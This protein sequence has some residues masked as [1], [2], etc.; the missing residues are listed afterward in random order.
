MNLLPFFILILLMVTPV[1]SHA[2]TK[3]VAIYGD[4][5]HVAPKERETDIRVVLVSDTHNVEIPL[6]LFPS[7]DLLLHAGDHTV[8]GTKA[9]MQAAASWLKALATRYTHGCVTVGGNHDGSLDTQS[10]TNVLRVSTND[11]ERARVLAGFSEDEITN[12]AP[13]QL[14]SGARIRLLNHE[15]V[16]VAGLR[17]FGSP[18]VP[19]SPGSYR[20]ASGDPR[21]YLGF[22]REG[23]ALQK[24][25]A[26]IPRDCHILM[27]HAP[28]RGLLDKSLQYGGQPRAQPIEIGAPEL[29]AW[30]ET[31]Y[32][33]CPALHVFGHEHDSR[34]VLKSSNFST[35]FCNAA[36]VNGDRSVLHDG[37]HYHMKP[38]FRAT[39]FD[40]RLE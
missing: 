27:T 37:G 4:S 21:R 14:F 1:F 35:V 5:D 28:A 18:Y 39:V 2:N 3:I 26:E 23:E 9:Q 34:G 30:L 36:A 15:A 22:H 40:F 38:D 10:V 31:C 8:D 17:I 32:H 24:L 16:T 29:R 13:Q 6:E 25:Y 12:G 33:E 11:L 19:L 20:Y 7:G